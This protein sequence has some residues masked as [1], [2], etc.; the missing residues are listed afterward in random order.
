MVTLK[1]RSHLS[2][3]DKVASIV[4]QRHS[5]TKSRRDLG[6]DGKRWDHSLLDCFLT[7]HVS[8]SDVS[9]SWGRGWASSCT[10]L[11]REAKLERKISLLA[12]RSTNP[13][14][15]PPQLLAMKKLDAIS[16]I[17]HMPLILKCPVSSIFYIT[18][19]KNSK[20]LFLNPKSVHSL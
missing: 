4:K 9:E 6:G 10:T 1:L 18:H 7:F 16:R 19:P 8:V 13:D 5:S 15:P 11:T 2:S 3:V 17:N 12:Q 14:E 20:S